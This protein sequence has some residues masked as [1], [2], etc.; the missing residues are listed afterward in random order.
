MSNDNKDSKK[1]IGPELMEFLK[2]TPFSDNYPENINSTCSKL[3][4]DR[5]AK[6][7]LKNLEEVDP[8]AYSS[9]MH[10]GFSYNKSQVSG[11]R[12]SD[13]GEKYIGKKAARVGAAI[14]AAA[15]LATLGTVTYALNSCSKEQPQQ[16]PVVTISEDSPIPT[17]PVIDH[18]P[19]QAEEEK[20]EFP[21]IIEDTHNLALT[22]EN[23]SDALLLKYKENLSHYYK[24]LTGKNLGEFYIKQR[25]TEV[26]KD[27]E[28]N[29]YHTKYNY[30]EYK[31]PDKY[32]TDRYDDTFIIYSG[33]APGSGE[34]DDP[35]N[36]LCECVLDY[37]GNL[38]NFTD[39]NNSPD[40]ALRQLVADTS[41]SLSIAVEA[42]DQLEDPYYSSQPDITE[43]DII[44]PFNNTTSDVFSNLDRTEYD[45]YTTEQDGYDGHDEY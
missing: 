14:F 35:S 25:P 1:D 10:A 12:T 37:D 23:N 7:A 38:I 43:K 20:A 22:C 45:K 27:S 13:S 36:I 15:I 31:L 32:S 16:D 18:S 11:R 26:S 33:K 24:E 17:E 29:I 28:G 8:N 42:I 40:Q 34:N 9:F 6:R 19:A 5:R 3:R 41:K 44:I 2:E 30:Q 4:A 39:G 21:A